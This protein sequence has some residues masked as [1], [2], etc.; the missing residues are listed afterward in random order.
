M[1]APAPYLTANEIQTKY[2]SLSTVADGDL[3][4]L[5][6]E[7]E[8]WVE[9]Y[10]GTAYRVREATET[11]RV[12]QA[13]GALPLKHNQ[14]QSVTEIEFDEGTA[15]AVGDVIPDGRR[16]VT[17]YQTWPVGTFVTVTYTHGYA[18]PPAG[19]LRAC[20][21]FVRNEAL[22]D[23]SEKPKNTT[24][25]TEP[26]SGQV[27]RESTADWRNDRPSR[28]LDVIELVNQVDDERPIFVA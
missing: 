18:A 12:A 11:V 20:Y 19:I 16:I 3:E 25:Y 1:T 21:R 8:E 26:A 10:R 4:D 23:R 17:K 14:I 5:V 15:P 9:L 24:S 2:Q 22:L 27:F 7:F 28:W 6:A 13:S